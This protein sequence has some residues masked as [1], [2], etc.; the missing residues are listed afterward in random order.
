[1]NAKR[2]PT[3]RDKSDER[4]RDYESVQPEK[5]PASG[6]RPLESENDTARRGGSHVETPD[7]DER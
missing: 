3:P 4:K 2:K 7:V 1:M 5:T 6:E